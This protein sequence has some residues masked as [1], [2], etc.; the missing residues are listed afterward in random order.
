MTI[1]KNTS[2]GPRAVIMTDAS[3]VFIEPGETKSIAGHRINGIPQGL[4]EIDPADL[5]DIGDPLPPKPA[6]LGGSDASSKPL[7]ELKRDELEAL[8]KQEGIDLSKIEGS[9]RGGN[10][11]NDDIREAIE[12]KRKASKG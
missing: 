11:L 12:A 4:I 6:D 2:K 9:G 3:Y 10:V 5:A 7:S 8:A 1:L